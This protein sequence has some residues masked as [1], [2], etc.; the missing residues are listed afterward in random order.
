MTRPAPLRVLLAGIDEATATVLREELGGR[1]ALGH[2]RPGDPAPPGDTDTPTLL[3]VGAGVPAPAGLV[4]TMQSRTRDLAVVVVTDPARPGDTATLALLAPAERL[5][6]VPAGEPDTLAGTARSMLDRL[7]LQH[8]Y[9]AA[10]AAAQRALLAESEISRQPGE[11]LF[12]PLHHQVLIGTLAVDGADRII[13]WNRKAGDILSLQADAAGRGLLPLF[14]PSVRARLRRHLAHAALL[15]APPALFERRDGDGAVQVLRMSAQRVVN[16]DGTAHTLIVLEDVTG[17]TETRRQL[18]ERTRHALLSSDV[19]A[20]LTSSGPLRQ[21]LQRSARAVVDRLGVAATHIWILQPREDTLVLQASA[22]P[23]SH[24]ED[25]PARITVGDGEIG[26]IAAERTPHLSD[27]VT[28]DPRIRPQRGA[29]RDGVT[30]FAGCPLIADGDLLGVLAL[31]TRRPLPEATHETLTGIADQIAV[32]VR[33]DRLLNRLTTTA[34]ALQAPLLPPE[35]PR[36]PGLDIAARYRAQGDSLDVGGD[37]YDVFPLPDGQWALALGDVCGKGPAAAAV[38]GL[39][40]HTLWAAARQNPDPAHVLPLIHQALRR[41]HSPFCTLVYAVLDPTGTC[42]RLRIACAGHPAPLLRRHTGETLL[43]DRHG[44]L[45]GAFDLTGQPV[46]SATLHPGDSLVLY[47]DGFTEGA[48]AHLSREP[49]DL[50]ALVH[51]WTGPTGDRPADELAELLFTDAVTRW[52]GRLRD[53]LALVA[54]T[55]QPETPAG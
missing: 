31:H 26:V 41:E 7:A 25:T 3:V 37:F 36:L 27:L 12:G 34:Q 51:R 15:P 2:F 17:T 18:A 47:T 38:T 23:S 24:R 50:A 48:G 35:L 14:P 54:V 55:A 9:H 21:R 30:A 45:L 22:G 40:R 1:A 6:H 49:E 29:L 8:A 44:P 42:T 4:G 33:Q 10:Q 19:A 13:A 53:D 16:S 28:R 46:Q 11:Q 5:A 43:L 20:A 32:G 52:T 39:V